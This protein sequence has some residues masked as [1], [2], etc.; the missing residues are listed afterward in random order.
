M[1]LSLVN[2]KKIYN[3]KNIIENFSLDI[4]SK[5]AVA[6][7]APPKSG[8]T[9][10]FNIIAGNIKPSSGEVLG[11]DK[12][13]L[14]IVE[15]EVSIS[16]NLTCGENVAAVM[17]NNSSDPKSYLQ[18]VFLDSLMDISIS[19]LNKAIMKRLAI[20][21]ALANNGD[22][23]L[24]DDPFSEMDDETKTI[25]IDIFKDIKLSKAVV[26]TTTSEN[27]AKNLADIIVYL[28]PSPLRIKSRTISA[29]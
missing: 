22:V 5:G 26:F 16:N 7:L 27:D 1:S 17:D 2:I 23:F 18:K 15:Q 21:M 6:L 3:K 8:K 25:I 19:K 24:L 11:L 20:A 4:P 13:S 29:L 9:T 10:L 28:E 14:S 12:T